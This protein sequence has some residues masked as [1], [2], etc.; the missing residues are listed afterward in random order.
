ME[1]QKKQGGKIDFK[2]LFGEVCSI[3][4]V[5]PE[6]PF[7]SKPKSGQRLFFEKIKDRL[8]NQTGGE[9]RGK[10]QGQKNFFRSFFRRKKW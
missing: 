7:L 10:K 4:G 6:N 8:Q 3:Y 2:E 5:D 9:K 1:E